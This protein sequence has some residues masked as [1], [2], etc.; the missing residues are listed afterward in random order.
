MPCNVVV[1]ISGSGSNLQAL[2]DSVA[3]DGN[4]AR[5]AAVICNRAGAHG[6]ERAKQA[7]IATELLDH[8]QFDGREAFDA[9]LI[10]AID[11]HQPDLVVLAG[12]MRILTPGFVQHYSGRLLNIHPSLLPKHKGLHTHQRAIE[13]GDSEHGC[14]VHFVTEEL[15]GGPLVVQAVLPVMADDTAESLASRVHQQEHL[16]YPLAVRWFAEGRLRLGAQG[17]MLDDQPLP[18]SGHLIRT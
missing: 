18:A 13:A 11:A 9:A 12:F 16:I 3:H 10:Q 17:A 7:G 15:D 8:K 4:P 14:S 2:I 6:L 5:I 1:L